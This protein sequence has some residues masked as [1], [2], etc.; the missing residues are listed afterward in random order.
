MKIL[1]RLLPVIF[2]AGFTVLISIMLYGKITM[3]EQEECWAN[4]ESAAQ[5]VN[6][7][8]TTKFSDEIVKLHM[9]E[10]MMLKDGNEEQERID[11]LHL[12]ILQPTTIFSRIDVL[13][14]DNTMLSNGS[15]HRTFYDFS[16]ENIAAAG[17]HITTRMTDPNSGDESIYYVLPVVKDGENCAILLGVIGVEKLSQ[18]FRPTIYDGNANF[19]ILDSNNG[20]F[21]M[22]SWHSELGNV[23]EDGTRERL[24]NYDD[25]KL[26]EMNASGS[27]GVT[28]FVS[29]TTGKP[30]YIY[31]M[32]ASMF[33]WQL[34]I[35]AEE[36]VIFGPLMYFRKVLM[37]AGAIEVLLLIIYFMWNIRTVRQL[38]KSNAEIESQKEQLKRLSYHDTL[39][40]MYN[41][42]KYM[43]TL[44]GYR[45]HRLKNV[46][47]LYID[48]NGLKYINDS[49]SHEAGDRYICDAAMAILQAFSGSSYRIGGDEFV[50]IAVDMAKAEF[51]ARLST[52]KQSAADRHVSLS[53]GS[54]WQGDADDLESLIKSAE[55]AMYVEKESYYAERGGRR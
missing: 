9:V 15:K 19:C 7:E 48:L 5:S 33:D 8:I 37:M 53:I 30:M 10:S 32:P 4:L 38:E 24:A 26:K 20:D 12:D 41:R 34:L 1:K 55:K 45:G 11:E 25:V 54:A 23:Y 42:N 36:D 46:G 49:Q 40:T 44:D 3:R 13:Y 29:K 2:V 16:F 51:D 17:E 22:D 18:L 52:L 27:T 31:Y 28:A 14:P 6:K 35:F 39:T 47:V 21:I 50:V 43:D